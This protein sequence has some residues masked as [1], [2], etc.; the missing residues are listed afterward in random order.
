MRKALISKLDL[1]LH[2]KILFMAIGWLNSMSQLAKRPTFF[3][4][5][6][7]LELIEVQRELANSHRRQIKFNT[8]RSRSESPIHSFY[9]QQDH[10]ENHWGKPF[11]R[12]LCLAIRQRQSAQVDVE[13]AHVKKYMDPGYRFRA[14]LDNMLKRKAQT[15][16]ILQMNSNASLKG[17]D[18]F[19][20]ISFHFIFIYLGTVAPS[21]YENCFSG[22]RGTNVTSLRFDSSLKGGKKWCL[23]NI[24][25]KAIPKLRSTKRYSS[26]PIVSFS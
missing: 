22:G 17:I 20:F 9:E 11:R 19:H 3:L 18:S 24:K 25:F 13:S 4:T 21:V 8:K 26:L 1:W 10:T 15:Y 6:T 2:G 5:H 23:F 12:S 7:V 16:Q 14:G